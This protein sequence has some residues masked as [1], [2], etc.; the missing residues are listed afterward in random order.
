[1]KVCVLTFF[2][3]GKMTIKN[4]LNFIGQRVHVQSMVLAPD[5]FGPGLGNRVY[6]DH[7]PVIETG[8]LVG[9]Y[10]LGDFPGISNNISGN[11]CLPI[12]SSTLDTLRG[13]NECYITIVNKKDEVLFNN[14][15]YSSI[16]PIDGKVKPYNAVN[17][18][19]K[20][21]FISVAP[22]AIPTGPL[23]YQ[24]CFIMRYQKF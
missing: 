6:F 7:I 4:D 23:T 24:I 20:K 15:P 5:S 18:D 13:F 14:I 11:T 22:G 12:Q 17:I 21:S 3:Y 10:T 9:I 16:Y 1:M 2:T 19:S 8:Q